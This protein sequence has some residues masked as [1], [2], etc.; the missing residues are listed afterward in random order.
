MDYGMANGL[1]L[2]IFLSCPMYATVVVADSKMGHGW[3]AYSPS[4]TC[5]ID[6]K[7]GACCGDP[8]AGLLL[9]SC[10]ITITGRFSW[11]TV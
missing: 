3:Y 9:L 10:W 6:S 11:R 8:Q 1:N 5:A 4:K 2:S 7:I